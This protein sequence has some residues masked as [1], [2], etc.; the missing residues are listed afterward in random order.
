MR[1]FQ[2]FEGM[3]WKLMYV[4][5]YICNA[6]RDQIMMTVGISPLQDIDNDNH[7]GKP[8]ETINMFRCSKVLQRRLVLVTLGF[9]AVDYIDNGLSFNTGN[10]KG[11]LYHNY[12]LMNFVESPSMLYSYVLL[13]RYVISIKILIRLKLG[14]HTSFL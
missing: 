11:D 14:K 5:H 4:D 2:R 10:L 7:Q 9:S 1:N 8:I 6:K 13:K 3:I 12:F